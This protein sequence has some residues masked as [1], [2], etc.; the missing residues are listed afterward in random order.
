V[1]PSQEGQW[2]SI[3]GRADQLV[4][5]FRSLGLAETITIEREVLLRIFKSTVAATLAWLAAEVINSP[6]PALASLAAIIVLQITVRASLTRSIQ[7]TAAVIL[8]LGGALTLGK[9]L[10]LH[11]WSIAL[12]VLVGLVAG[13]LFRL[14][15]LSGQVAISAMLA[16]SLGR[17]YGLERT[18]DTVLGAVIAVIVNAILAPASH[19]S[20]ASRTLR[21]LGEDLG[22]L[23]SDIG[24]GLARA[25]DDAVPASLSPDTIRRWLI[26]S[27]DL[28]ADSRA[29]TATVKQSEESLQYN[30]FNRSAKTDLA[31]LSRL[32][33]ARLAM[34]HCITQTIGLV[35]SL[36][37]LTQPIQDRDVR[38]A[39]AAIGQI[40]PAAGAASSAFA[41]LQEN[42]S[43][44]KDRASLIQARVRALD[45]SAIAA[46]AVA[47]LAPG[48]TERL[49]GSILVDIDR[50]LN[51]I[52]IENGVHRGAVDDSGRDGP[53]LTVAD[54]V[55][56][57]DRKD[58]QE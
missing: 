6:R 43:A 27:R 46:D 9:L 55:D 58:A 10:G 40:L 33:E 12:V 28:V 45:Q 19:V 44:E 30:R 47:R 31:Q 29:A 16:I 15:A 25:S 14:G 18:I 8:G 48:S 51:E 41:R 49:L 34:D 11:W 20:A 7:L 35:R 23:L 24:R 52:D 32:T 3:R 57:L 39:L 37:D 1:T 56:S 42:P 13:E 50:L 36:I 54:G 4:A 17:G 26:R 38:I 22:A 53:M 21:A 5:R 2:T